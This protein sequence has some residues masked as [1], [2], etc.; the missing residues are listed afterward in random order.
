MLLRPSAT[1]SLLSIGALGVAYAALALSIGDAYYQSVLALVPVWAVLALAWNIPGGYG[2]L[3]SFGHAAFFGIGAYVVGIGLA[4][5]GITP[6]AGLVLAAV[7][8]AAAGALIGSITLRLRGHYFALAM[9]AYPLALLNVMNWLGFQEVV[10]PTGRQQGMLSM[11]TDDPRVQTCITLGFLLISLVICWAIEQSRTGLSLA[12]IRED[13]AAAEAAGIDARRIKLQALTVSGTMAAV[14]GGLYAVLLVVVTPAGVFGLN[15]SAQAL[16]LAL[17]GGGG[18][19]WGPVIGAA[20]LIPAAT[21]LNG[22]F[23]SILPGLQGIIFGAAIVVVMLGAPE[24]VFWLVRDAL[25]RHGEAE[26]R[27]TAEPG[28]EPRIASAAPDEAGTLLEMEGL[29]KSYGGVQAIADVSLKVGRGELLG[30]IGPNGAGKTTLFNLLSGFTRPDSGSIRF[31]GQEITGLRP[32]RICRLGMGR[33]F[34]TPRAFARLSV[35]DNVVVG[36]LAASR[37]DADALR[38]G[39]AALERTGL[40]GRAGTLADG[41]TMRD[42]RLMEIARALASSPKLVLLDEPLAGLGGPDVAAVLDVLRAISAE[43]VTICI[44]D[45]TIHAMAGLVDR[46]VVLDRGMRISAGAPASVMQDPV[47]IEAYLGRKHRVHA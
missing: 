21:L 22:F 45:H 46:F 31:C 8:G 4:Q 26:S 33:T 9:L 11:Q 23:G 1:R 12:A 25:R 20:T 41:L 43:A 27:P 37:D 17:F 39:W 15:V 40:A 32:N 29:C 28:R 38:R 10:L 30:I 42:L 13:E 5:F 19:L 24:G 44:I 47:V 35:L 34:Q 3:V 6:Y 16:V 2:G 7:A 14:A 18:T 36:A